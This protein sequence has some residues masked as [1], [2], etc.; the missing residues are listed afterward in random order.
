M[1]TFPPTPS[2]SNP[3]L[4]IMLL[5]RLLP[6][7]ILR[8][9]HSLGIEPRRTSPHPRRHHRLRRRHAHHHPT[10][11]QIAAI[12]G[13]LREPGPTLARTVVV[14]AHVFELDG[15]G[16]GFEVGGGFVVEGDTGVGFEGGELADA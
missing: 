16:F 10:T 5:K 7:N 6:Q 15:G 11:L 8:P 12:A 2:K 1:R 13:Q 9:H 14:F 3:N 4:P